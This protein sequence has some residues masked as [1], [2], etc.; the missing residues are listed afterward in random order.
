LERRRI[1]EEERKYQQKIKEEELAK[2]NA[3]L[4]Q[5][6]EKVRALN[7]KLLYSDT[8]QGR[9][10]QIEIKNYIKEIEKK[11]EEIYHQETIVT[12]P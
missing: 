2:A 4:F 3:K 1:D 10:E 8:L 12:L 11:R 6:T 9:G 5:D 7:S